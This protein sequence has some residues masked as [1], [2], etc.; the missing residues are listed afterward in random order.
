[1]PSYTETC[2]HLCVKN[3]LLNTRIYISKKDFFDVKTHTL[4]HEL[5]QMGIIAS[6]K[7]YIAYDIFNVSKVDLD[8]LISS[9]FTDPVSEN[10]LFEL[11]IH[12]HLL[13]IEYLPGQFDIRADAAIQCCQ[14]ILEHNNLHI[15]T[16]QVVGINNAEEKDVERIRKHLINTVDSREKD[17][18]I[19][20]N[21][22]LNEPSA[23]SIIQG[24]TLFDNNQL[25]QF[26]LENKLSIDFEDLICIQ[27]YFIDENREPTITEIKVLD[28]YWSDHCRHTTFLTELKNIQI[29]G[30]FALE[31][32]QSYHRFLDIKNKLGRK[33]NPNSLMEL[34]TIPMKYF[35][36]EK[37]LPLFFQTKEN[38]A[39]TIEIDVDVNGENE[40][41]LLLFKNETHNHPTEI[42]PFG[43]ASTCIGGAIRDPLSGRAFVYQ[44]MRISG[45]G[46]P[47]ENENDTLSSKLSQKKISKD[48]ALGYSSYGN[49]IGLSTSLVAEIFDDGYKA[50]HFECGFVVAA[51]KKEFVKMEDPVEGDIVL[52]LGGDTGRDGIGGASGSSMEHN[53]LSI[54]T[55]QAE[56]QK[57]NAITERKIQKLFKRAE[58][59]NLIKKCNDFGAGGLCV[60]IG[61][62]ADSIDIDLNLV[63]LKYSGLNGSEIALSESQE[64]MAVVV[65]KE[66]VA[67]FIQF[68]LEENLNATMVANITNDGL[69]KM[70]WNGKCILNLKRSF[71]ATN[72]GKRSND[73]I[74]FVDGVQDNKNSTFSKNKFFE[75]LS[76]KEVASQ[77]GMVEHFDSTVLGNTCL[78]PFGGKY[79]MTPSDVSAHFICDETYTTN[80]VSIASWGYHPAFTKSNLYL[81]GMYSII[82]SICKI[83]AVGGEYNK[84]YLTFQEYFEKLGNDPKKWGK[85]FAVLLGAFEAQYQL[86][87]AAIGG[88]DSMSGTFKDINVPPTFVSFAVTTAN[89][90]VI[91][92]PEFKKTNSFIYLCK[93]PVASN[94]IPKW[95]ALKLIWDS[96]HKHIQEKKIISVKHIKDGGIASAIAQMSFGNKIG[97][98]VN[99]DEFLLELGIGSFIIE[100][101]QKLDDIFFQQIGKTNTTVTLTFNGI[102]ISLE[103]ALISWTSTFEKIFPTSTA[104][105]NTPMQEIHSTSNR[106]INIGFGNPT[107]FI[108]VFPGTNCEFETMD[109]FAKEGARI[110]TKNFNNLNASTIQQS[111]EA[112]ST[113]I[114]QSQILVLS[115]GFSAGDEPDGSAKFIINILK[116][117][118][119]KD[120]VHD[121]LHKGGLILGICNG[122]QALIKS[123]LL[124][125]GE[126]KE[127]DNNSPTLTY[128]AIGRHVSQMVQIKVVNDQSPW[129]QG[130]KDQSFIIPVSH[131]EGRFYAS[132]DTLQNLLNK[133]QIATQYVGS[134]NEPTYLFP[135]N[136]NG[137][138][139][140]IEGMISEDGKIFGRMSHPERVKDGRFK[141][142]PGVEYQNIFKKGVDY[143]LK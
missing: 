11:P 97:V 18:Q 119:I 110:A 106:I 29:K 126:I 76:S 114:N 96:I 111:I 2:I 100:S 141:N 53:D 60:A 69:L 129:L 87:I 117:K 80:T 105:Q 107:V 70:H 93:M 28:T 78:M 142:I 34:A 71:L 90:S 120:S 8:S 15:T 125:Y 85:P 12:Q 38:N 32:E 14:L 81:G 86:G 49:Q 127:L 124:P 112:F 44:A 113:Q 39:A 131:G 108:P 89:A 36:H 55:M 88:K 66:D 62:L 41:W 23:V 115:G 102:E 56:V 52:L 43:G 116:N 9:V 140:A 4:N 101:T 5:K 130:M 73:V 25:I 136:P 143:F 35:L 94:N 133:N 31:V 63:P 57:G 21:P 58:A 91:I 98:E 118:K 122:F 16:S 77:K 74:A 33:N 19:L 40:K 132:N 6:V 67:K 135:F 3:T 20:D 123:G 103:E 10:C 72:G 45:A 138:I 92:S 13:A 46:N 84:C 59:I 128:N 17:L 99:T 121:F 27:K 65:R 109:A 104:L 137:S 54:S 68:A 26:I 50:K 42:E 1:M 48:A 51:V 139:Y 7:V 79:Q 24:F 64:R 47:L 83:V 75:T 37:K 95:D 134:N 22:I 82:E 61:E 30:S